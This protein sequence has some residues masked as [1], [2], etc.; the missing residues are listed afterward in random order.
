MNLIEPIILG[1]ALVGGVVGA[2]LGFPAGLLPGLGGLLA[3]VVLGGLLGPPVFILGGL[4]GVTLFRGP[5]HTWA[6]L[7]EMFGSRP[8]PG[9]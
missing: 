2:T 5:R 8:G 9:D 7:R 6:L 3:G 1:G 4:V